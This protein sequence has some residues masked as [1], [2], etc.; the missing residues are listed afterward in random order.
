MPSPS[1]NP[2][3]QRRTRQRLLQEAVRLFSECGFDAV[4]VNQIVAAAGVNKR[5][6]YHYFGSKEGI[7]QAALEEVYARI[8]SIKF[9]VI[10]RES[11]PREKLARLLET[12]FAFLRENPKFMQLL[13]WENL[14]NGRRAA[15][16]DH[17]L[18]KNLILDRFRRIVEEGIAAGDFRADLNLPNNLIHFLGLCFIISLES[19]EYVKGDR[20]LIGGQPAAKRSAG[21]R[22]STGSRPSKRPRIQILSSRE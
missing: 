18:G 2:P 17:T 11:T 10:D 13:L 9:G 3:K 15:K 1:R 19:V 6:V 21:R 5:M 12:T 14:G 8:Q 22:F 7:F 4:S 16:Q 20:P